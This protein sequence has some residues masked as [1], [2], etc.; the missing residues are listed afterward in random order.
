MGKSPEIPTSLIEN[1]NGDN[2]H[3]P[4][5]RAA[6]FE[7]GPRRAEHTRAAANRSFFEMDRDDAVR[8]DVVG[9]TRPP[10]GA[11]APG[12]LVCYKRAVNHK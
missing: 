6:P 7:D 5:H 11:F 3:L 12:A 1:M 2:R 8:R 4:A 9:R 10:R